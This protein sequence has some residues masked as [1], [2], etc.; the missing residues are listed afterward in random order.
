MQRR[1]A[2]NNK[3]TGERHPGPEASSRKQNLRVMVLVGADS[4]SA[5]CWLS[6]ARAVSPSVV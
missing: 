5:R 6:W 4:S 1:A 3:G 2:I